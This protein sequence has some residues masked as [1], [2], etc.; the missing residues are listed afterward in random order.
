VDEMPAWLLRGV[1]V[2][3]ESVVRYIQRPKRLGPTLKEKK[4]C[5]T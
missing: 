5:T 2:I 3:D 1:V 4:I